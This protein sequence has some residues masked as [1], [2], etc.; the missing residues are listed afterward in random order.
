MPFKFK[1]IV[2]ACENNGIA[3]NKKL[4]WTIPSETSY[5]LRMTG[6]VKDKTKKN[7]VIVGRKTFE[8]SPWKPHPDCIN[9][10]LSRSGLD[11]SQY[12][13][14]YAF[15]SLDEAIAKLNDEEFKK[16]YED[17]W[18]IGGNG[19][20]KEVYGTEH[21]YRV[22]FTRVF[23]PY[24]CDTFFP[25]MPETVKLVEDPRVPQGI[26]EDAGHKY[27]VHVYENINFKE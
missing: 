21:F 5:Y 4:P 20:Y 12:P 27:I 6:E 17:S 25:K 10:V 15:K 14:T 18:V 13:D 7:V 19:V 23:H 22:Y 1:L 11:V 2:A 24:D 8:E 26:I 16:E 3:K 9:F